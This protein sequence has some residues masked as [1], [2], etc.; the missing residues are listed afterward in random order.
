MRLLA[1]KRRMICST[2]ALALAWLAFLPFAR[3]DDPDTFSPVVSY[4]YYD[5]LADPVTPPPITSPVASYQY[6]DWPGDENLT[7]QNSARASYFFQG[8]SSTGLGG[9]VYD[10]QSGQPLPN[11][12]ITLGGMTAINNIAGYYS[13]TYLTNAAYPLSAVRTGYLPFSAYVNPVAT[14]SQDIYLVPDYAH[15]PPGAL[16]GVITDATTGSGKAGVIVT[17]SGG[18]SATSDSS[19]AYNFPAVTAGLYTISTNAANY[20]PYSHKVSV[21]GDTT[22]NILLTKAA[23]VYGSRTSS[24]YSADPVNTA[25]GNYVYDRDDLKLPGKGMPFVFTRSYNSQDATDGPLGFGWSHGYNASLSVDIAGIVMLRWGDGKTETYAPNGSGGY[26]PQYGVFDTLTAGSGGAYSLRKK[27]QT[28]YQFDAGGKLSSITDKNGNTI[29]LTYTG[30]NLNGITDTAGRSISFTYDASNRITKITDPLARTVQYAYDANG[31]LITATDKNVRATYYTYDAN[32]QLLTVT[33]PRGNVVVTNAYDAAKRV[34]NS[35]R[36]AKNGQT[37]YVYDTVN[38]K[39]TVT[40]ALGKATI[41]YHDDLLRLVREDDPLVNKARYAYDGAGN[42]IEVTDKNGTTTSYGYDALGN[43]VSKTDAVGN[44]TWITYDTMNNPLTRTDALANV[45]QFT[46]DAKGNLITA[47]DATGAA[48]QITYDVAGLPLV[49]TDP[50]GHTRTNTYDAS[51]NLV[52]VQDAAGNSTFLTYDAGG[53]KLTQT[54]ALNHTTTLV[55]DNNDNLLSATDSAGTVTYAYDANNNRL[56]ARDRAGNT[57]SYTYDVKDL[58]VTTT[59]PLSNA[60]T[61]AYDA[62]DRKITMTDARNNATQSAYDGTGN[63]ITVTDALGKATQFT[64][65]ANGNQI[66]IV[67]P[68][69]K[70]TAKTYD[71]LNRLIAVTDSLGNKTQ[72]GYDALGR[73]ITST[74]ANGGVTQFFY[75]AIGRLTQVTDANGGAVKYA[76]DVAG[77]RISISDANGH[78]T[79]Y[80]YDTL[81]RLIG[82]TEASGGTCQY[83]YDVVGN[84]VTQND[85]NGRTIQYAY[86]ASNRLKTITYP[87]GT[88]VNFTY[89]ANGNRTGM[90]DV[91]GS[92]TCVFDVMNRMTSATDAFGNVVSYAYDANGN[93]VSLS[94]PGNKTV[95]YAYDPVNRL[96]T[97]KDWLNGVTSYAY[98]DAG[99]LTQSVNPNGTTATYGYDGASRLTGLTNAK[100]DLSTICSYGLT[101]DS[102]GN[103]K[104]ATQ[105]E[106]LLPVIPS[107]NTAYAYDNDDR[108]TTVGTATC[109]YD[110]NGNMTGRGAA[111]FAYDFENRL[112]Q[113]TIAGATSQYQYDGVGNRKA[114]IVGGVGKRFALD[115]NSS[116]SHVLA[117]TDVSNAVAAYYVYGL[118]LIS[119]ITPAGTASY[120]HYDIRGSAIALSNSAGTVTDEYAYEAFGKVA[121][122]QGTT[123]NP[124]KYVG[125][126]G[127]MDEANDLSYIRA[128]YYSPDLG[129]FITKDPLT[130]KDG[131]SQSLNRYVYVSNNPVRFVD[132]NG[133]H[134]NE[135]SSMLPT[136]AVST[137]PIPFHNTLV[138]SIVVASSGNQSDGLSFSRTVAENTLSGILEIADEVSQTSYSSVLGAFSFISS[139][140]DFGSAAREVN[141]SLPKQIE[142]RYNIDNYKTDE[143]FQHAASHD[144]VISSELN[145]IKSGFGVTGGL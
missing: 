6:F 21:C 132:V 39:T 127:V 60:T 69:G 44:V 53:R 116:L 119:M 125:R 48:S 12:A 4:Q 13:F 34:V 71:A 108:L 32:H 85:P 115:T 56:T 19:G 30:G 52:Q 111:T 130:G 58:L 79:A 90:T 114:T 123:A 72:Y 31:N 63:L 40:D 106:P 9:F 140:L 105:N 8:S 57:T 100:S 117:E 99:S 83:A 131:D 68:L 94:Y 28:V 109:A 93:R 15:C 22:W 47:T 74:D 24:G 80:A 33:D 112:T 81:N 92:S 82:K 143:E 61:N 17:L 120:Y 89:D 141:K 137:D 87:T 36:D 45:T 18:A 16:S 65:D 103:H 139:L 101:L 86:D 126:F 43:V 102:V 3:A 5:S 95:T 145:L 66:G 37:S 96:S 144:P 113:S 14:P 135:I 59:D 75:D 138:A 98:D 91:L 7:F 142:D 2:T 76:Y 1:I 128:R 49:Q 133:F 50:L 38:H 64:Y 55:Y 107:A 73:R 124:F 46:Y 26:T 77:N 104:Q 78:V 51:G 110:A 20:L 97:V 121:N 136:K 35:Q 25:T 11:T 67:N 23:T 70:M 27:D 41:Y 129:R 54:D 84:R 62:L 134:K 42:R 88:P 10:Q 118:G 122:S 29:T